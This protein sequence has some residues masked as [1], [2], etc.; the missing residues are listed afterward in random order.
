MELN[1]LKKNFGEEY[2]T[3]TKKLGQGKFMIRINNQKREVIGR[4]CGKMRH[5]KA[6]TSNWV[7]VN[8]VVLFGFRNYDLK[9]VDILYVYSD[10]EARQLRK[11]KIIDEKQRNKEENDGGFIFEESDIVDI[12]GI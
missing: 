3:I 7:D 2:G 10:I 11:D 1:I 5:R 6:K 4:L 9:N 8:S 12:D